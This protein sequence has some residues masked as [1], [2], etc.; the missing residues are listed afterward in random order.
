MDS[1]RVFLQISTQ[2]GAFIDRYPNRLDI[3]Y[4]DGL[5]AHNSYGYSKLAFWNGTIWIP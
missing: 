5:E 2:I 4:D 1:R 3:I